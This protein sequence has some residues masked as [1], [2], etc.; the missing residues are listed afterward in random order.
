M[1]S[2]SRWS[3]VV[4]HPECV[5]LGFD[6][7]CR[8]KLHRLVE[9]SLSLDRDWFPLYQAQLTWRQV[10]LL[11]LEGKRYL[12]A[13]NDS[14]LWYFLQRDG[15]HHSL[16]FSR[17]LAIFSTNNSSGEH[18]TLP[19]QDWCCVPDKA[20]T[21]NCELGLSLITKVWESCFFPF[22]P[23]FLLAVS[24][25]CSHSHLLPHTRGYF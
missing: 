21:W 5:G 13:D 9:L 8:V 10:R 3:T 1:I 19:Y 18:K 24:R 2:P 22:S 7:F 6:V 11:M 20:G 4:L 15:C 16:G 17:Y 25:C 12:S 14:K 23:F